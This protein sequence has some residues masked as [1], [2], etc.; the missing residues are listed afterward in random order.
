MTTAREIEA[1]LEAAID[2]ES[3]QFVL[4]TLRDVCYAKGEHL[5]SNWQDAHTARAWERAGRFLDQ[6]TL[7]A[8]VR[9]AAPAHG[10]IGRAHV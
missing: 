8:A 3:L 5:R 2:S 4:S 1:Q 9:D 7:N 6:S 10:E